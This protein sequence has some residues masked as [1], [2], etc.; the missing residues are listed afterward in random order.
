MAGHLQRTFLTQGSTLRLLHWQADSLPPSRLGSPPLSGRE[1]KTKSTIWTVCFNPTSQSLGSKCLSILP[2]CRLLVSVTYSQTLSV[3]GDLL[4]LSQQIT[5]QTGTHPCQQKWYIFTPYI[6]SLLSRKQP[7]SFQSR[8]QSLSSSLLTIV[9]AP[10][11]PLQVTKFC[12]SQSAVLNVAEPRL[13]STCLKC[14]KAN[15]LTLG[16]GEEKY[17]LS[18]GHQESSRK[19]S[20]SALFTVPKPWT[21]WVTINCG[22]FWKRWEYRPPDLPL[23]K[24]VCR[25]GSNS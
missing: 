18:V 14:S 8:D 24:P 20:I 10:V 6:S 1:S 16:C 22:K 9:T 4:H 7:W 2:A 17:S 21:V 19:T 13:G 23:E 25:S 3:Y 12:V 11:A 15:L 5:F